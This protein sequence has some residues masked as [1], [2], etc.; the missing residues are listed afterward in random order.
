MTETNHNIQ[1]LK[2]LLQELER[3][4]AELEEFIAHATH[5][6]KEP[7]RTITTG[8]NI[9]LKKYRGH[10]DAEAIKMLEW[11]EQS[12]RNFENMVNSLREYI[13]ADKRPA[14]P[15]VVDLEEIVYAALNDLQPDI[16]ACRAEIILH[17]L[18]A[19]ET[20]KLMLKTVFLHLIDNALK[21][22]RAATPRIIISA[23]V[24]ADNAIITISDNGIGIHPD[25]L[26]KIM[27]PFQRLHSKFEIPGMGLGLPLCKKIVNR[28]G[29]DIGIESTPA[30]GTQVSITLPL[31]W[32]SASVADF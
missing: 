16:Q 6:I 21:Y 8:C 9:L 17:D 18:P 25:Y 2:K 31:S 20:D 32:S 24:V 12:A 19:I 7:M 11:M 4:N 22:R 28:L 27:Q 14:R 5:D 26:N 3:R 23:Q 10:L 15:E 30:M 29:G 1:K 13:K